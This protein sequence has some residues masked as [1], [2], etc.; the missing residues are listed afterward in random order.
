[1]NF[2]NG[3]VV[4]VLTCSAFVAA[5]VAVLPKY[6]FP[7]DPES[8]WISNLFTA[9]EKAYKE[10]LGPQVLFIA[11]S[12]GLLGFDSQLFA[13]LTGRHTVNFGVHAGLGIPYILSRAE[14][15]LKPGDTAILGFEYELFSDGPNISRHRFVSF[16]D[17]PYIYT[18]SFADWS[19]FLWGYG[20]IDFAYVSFRKL[21][22]MNM[23][24]GYSFNLTYSGDFVDNTV[25]TSKSD[26]A[27][28]WDR[29]SPGK[30]N[31]VTF[32]FI[33]EF[34][35]RCKEKNINVLVSYP[36]IFRQEEYTRKAEFKDYFYS[37]DKALLSVSDG[38][39]GTFK[40]AQ[41]Q[42]SEMYDA[43]YHLNSVGRERFTSQLANYFNGHMGDK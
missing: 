32:D 26:Y 35:K 19:G 30:L 21:A 42:S 5:V 11:G 36:P 17:R 7:P 40:N 25:E 14:K 1:M 34:R 12:S 2:I 41:F 33:M 18:T 39:L 37:L 6:A 43:R 13:K 3:F 8:V 20:F 22:P 16:F 29:F 9:K 23:G 24:H 27:N 10:G 31:S 28:E 15:L 38:L 4:K